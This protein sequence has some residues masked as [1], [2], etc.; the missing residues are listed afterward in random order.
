MP[1]NPDNE[2]RL[3]VLVSEGVV[4]SVGDFT[5]HAKQVIKSLTD[6]EFQSILTI[7]KTVLRVAGEDAL[8]A[9]DECLSFVF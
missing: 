2:N 1:E 3:Q 8:R 7:R 5:P 9:S 6:T 4:Q